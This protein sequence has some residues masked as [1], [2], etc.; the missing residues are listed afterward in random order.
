[1]AVQLAVL[2]VVVVALADPM[3]AGPRALILIVDNSA[4]M[5]ATDV[6]P[7]RLAQAKE[8]G[9]RLIDGLR[10]CDSAAVL[11]AGDRVLFVDL[12]FV[13]LV[14][15]VADKLECVEQYVVMTDDEHMPDTS[16]P[17]AVAYEAFVS[18]G[19]DDDWPT[20]MKGLQ[21]A[22]YRNAN[23]GKTH[24]YAEGLAEPDGKVDM[25]AHGPRVAAFGFDHE[26]ISARLQKRR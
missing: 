13:P 17:N 6:E 10:P 24:Y 20:F 21:R 5:N 3:L 1:M 23:I 8:A 2:A 25:R 18:A 7:S 19:S 15:A 9:R 11:S 22:G 26:P 16:L 12:T 14:E 4:S